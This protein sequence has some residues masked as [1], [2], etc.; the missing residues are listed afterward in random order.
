MLRLSFQLFCASLALTTLTGA[1]FAQG[2]D[3][4]MIPGE[5]SSIVPY[6]L[7][8]GSVAHSGRSSGPEVV[9]RAVVEVRDAPWLRLNFSDLRLSGHPAT[10][11]ATILRIRSLKDGH[12]QYLNAESAA[13]WSN[14]SAYFNGNALLVEIV[15]Y[16]GSEASRLKMDEL[17]VGQA[18]VEP[19]SICGP[20]DDRVL[21]NDPRSARLMS[22]GC[23]AWL[24]DDLNR[25]FM[26]AGHCTVNSSSVTQF[27]VPLSNSN[28][29]VNH[30]GPQDQYP[31]QLASNQGV[32]SGAGNDW[33]YFATFPNSNHGLTA[34]QRQGAFYIKASAAPS[35]SGQSIRVTGYG[36]VSS[37]ISPTW[38]QV[39]KTHAGP[40]VSMSGTLIRYAMDTTG[41]NSGSA[42]Q[43][44]TTGLVIGVHTHAG[45]TSTGGSNQGTAIHHSGWQTAINNPLGIARSGRAP[46]SPPLY[47]AG[48]L[49][50][51]FG[52][53]NLGSGL[54]GKVGDIPATMQGLAYDRNTGFFYMS[55]SQRR[56]HRVTASGSSVLVGDITG[57][58]QIINGL[59]FDPNANVLY[60]MAQSNGQLFTINPNTAVATAVGPARG[61]QV[62]GIDYDAATN[63]LFG[64]DNSGGTTRLIR[65]NV[66]DGAHTVV[67]TA[68]HGGGVAYGLAWNDRDGQLYTVNATNGNLLLVERTTGASSIVGASNG[69]FGSGFG[70]AVSQLAAP[71]VDPSGFAIVRGSLQSG[72]LAQL[73]QSDDD[74]M[75]IWTEPLRFATVPLVEMELTSTSPTSTPSLVSFRLESAVTAQPANQVSQRIELFNY[76]ANSWESVDLRPAT[77]TDTLVNVTAAGDPSRFVHPATRQ[78]RARLSWSQN[79]GL[80]TRGWQVRLDQAVWSIQH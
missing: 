16:P 20:T 68:T 13:Q 5:S 22:V 18:P 34:F 53:L 42:V 72:G 31:V 43:D 47:L 26:S 1:A 12:V 50:N 21:S 15:A 19:R 3:E 51:N 7:D 80:V 39:Q 70:M 62:G 33:R 49:A 14:T 63:T 6:R 79:P 45:C 27:N 65:I 57:T 44:E 28:G 10:E 52:T 25:T 41:G 38:N 23:T 36:T 69:A 56:L 54:F 60:G 75:R 67:G 9:Y 4:T 55:D 64:L 59:G 73:L 24:H 2:C 77:G 30:P 40:Y 46:T 32:G 74:Y 66:V 58:T 8:S 76:V 29:S 71:Q 37:P 35:V 17:V 61:G 48:D 78:M 11:T